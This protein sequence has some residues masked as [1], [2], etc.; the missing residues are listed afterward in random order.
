MD[1]TEL[2]LIFLLVIT[3]PI[4]KCIYKDAKIYGVIE[5]SITNKYLPTIK[6]EF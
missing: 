6:Y 1:E 2:F 5:C 3:I 4:D